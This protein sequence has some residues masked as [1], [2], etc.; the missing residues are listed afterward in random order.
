MKLK[1]ACFCI[2]CEEIFPLEGN[3]PSCPSCTSRSFLPVSK[4]IPTESSLDRAN[5]AINVRKS[6]KNG[7]KCME[8]VA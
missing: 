1:D 7:Q 8:E 3:N 2:Q 4:Y 5:L 6:W